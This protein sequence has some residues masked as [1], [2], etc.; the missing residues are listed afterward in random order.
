MVYLKSK[1]S[2][3]L[4]VFC[5]SVLERCCCA[6]TVVDCQ[7]PTMRGSCPLDLELENSLLVLC[8]PPSIFS[9]EATSQAEVT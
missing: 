1:F 3:Y 5:A 9:K 4:L 6:G 7:G 2:D 8:L